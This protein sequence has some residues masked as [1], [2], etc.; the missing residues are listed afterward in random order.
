MVKKIYKEL[1]AKELR[2][3]CDP[4]VFKFKTTEEISEGEVIISQNRALKAIGFGLR[5]KSDGFNLYVSGIPG[6]G[7]STAIMNTVKEIAAR[8]PV[9][10]DICYLYNFDNPDEPRALTLPAGMGSQFE[11]DMEEFIKE[12]ETEIVKAFSGKDYEDKK[13]ELLEEIKE[14]KEKLSLELE[15]YAKSMGFTIQQSLTGLLVL[16][17]ID[18]KPMKDQDY[19]KLTPE[20]KK[21]LEDDQ[22]EIHEKIYE[23][24][25]NIRSIQVKKKKE[26]EELDKKI[27]FFTMWLLIDD[28]KGKYKS[29]KIIMEHLDNVVEDIL[30]NLSF[31]KK[32][33]ESE[34]TQFMQFQNSTDSLFNKYKVNL[35]IDNSDTEG[36]PVIIEHNPLYRNLLGTI[37]HIAQMGVLSTDFTM[38]KPGAVH[39]ANGGYLI[40]QAMDIFKDYYT[41]EALKKVMK[42][43]KAKIENLGDVYGLIST[44]TLKP[45]PV[46]LDIKVIIIGNPYIYHLL[47]LYDEDFRKLFKVKADFD[48]TIEKTGSM[49]NKYA[50][51][52]ATKCRQ[53]NLLPLTR[54][55]VAKIIDYS[56][57]ISDHKKK[58]TAK[59]ID[60]EDIIREACY[61]ARTKKA[62][63]VEKNHVVKALEEKTYRSNMI[64][65][66]LNEMIE[67]NTII[68][69]TTGSRVGQI[70]GLCVY[71][72]GDYSFG[73]PSRITVKTFNGR[74]NVM[75]IEREIRLS[76]KIHSKGVMILSSYVGHLFGQDKPLVFSASICF[77][78]LYDEIDGDSASSTELYCLLSSLSELPLRQ[79]IAVTGSVDQ[80]GNVQPIGGVNEKVE[81]FFR[82]CKLKGLTGKQGVVIPQRNV[83]H[84][85]LNDDV[86]D[87]VGK[88]D[89][90]IYPVSRIQEG[91]EILTGVKAGNR[92]KSGGFSKDSVFRM[93]DEKL[94][95]YTDIVHK[96]GKEEH[97]AD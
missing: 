45:E 39:R 90:H 36:A 44:A 7:R 95:K 67:E 9:P 40:L 71:D 52:I 69:E 17:L 80:N 55:A 89:F 21:K 87:A 8:E 61:W 12:L 26:I 6:T 33:E 2:N 43:K 75:N 72:M 48:T 96:Y 25:R 91:I 88:G 23:F 38:I 5:I 62:K 79:D 42:Y 49:V 29:Y 18:G 14:E 70:N 1:K 28:I 15:E 16:P 30:D 76:G 81:G 50:Q 85:M 83:K 60:I 4:K 63:V 92:L 13:K 10:E 66:K 78:Q 73:K 24:T 94:K 84:L 3:E 77:E 86:V 46:T 31:F 64:D 41:W 34:Q 58:L 82:V 37:E 93:A 11:D 27:G 22:K 68:I 35:L 19:T 47:Y 74:R 20:E 65:N 32:Y 59:F 51:L 97:K 56:S 53:E 54:D 57:R